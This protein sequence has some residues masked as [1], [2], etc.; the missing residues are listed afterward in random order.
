MKKT[1][2]FQIGALILMMLYGVYAT[3]GPGGAQPAARP[4]IC[5][6]ETPCDS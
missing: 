2:I 5:T 6:P 3:T 1:T 4:Q